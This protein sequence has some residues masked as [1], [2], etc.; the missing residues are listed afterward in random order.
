MTEGSENE[1]M[2]IRKLT[3]DNFFEWSIDLKASLMLK[4][5]YEAITGYDDPE[6]FVPDANELRRRRK[7]NQTAMCLILKSVSKIFLTDIGDMTSAMEAYEK[8]EEL[9]SSFGLLSSVQ[10]FKD[11]LNT[12][13]EE[14][15]SVMEYLKKIQTTQKKIQKAGFEFPDKV[16]AAIIIAGLHLPKYEGLVRRIRN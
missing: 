1:S 11:L 13:R 16:I 9:T 3:M 12:K 15:T 10:L 2:R 14:G 4:D 8:L 7:I 6:E 5:S